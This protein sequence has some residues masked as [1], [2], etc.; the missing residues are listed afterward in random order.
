M[1]GQ[2]PDDQEEALQTLMRAAEKCLEPQTFPLE[3][4]R[5]SRF[6]RDHGSECMR[7]QKCDME[8]P[9]V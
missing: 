8:D 7:L 1:T 5:M 3:L 4:A 2:V 9:H 6:N